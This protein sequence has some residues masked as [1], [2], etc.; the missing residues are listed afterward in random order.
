MSTSFT[1][2]V[3]TTEGTLTIPQFG[4]IATLDGRESQILV[5]EY[6]FGSHVLKYSTAEV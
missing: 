4:G 2:Q 5:S 3:N 6:T 1:L